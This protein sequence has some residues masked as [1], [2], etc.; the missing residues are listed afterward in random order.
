MN[1]RILLIDDDPELGV[2][3]YKWF[4]FGK[5]LMYTV[6]QLKGL[7]DL[8]RDGIL[9]LGPGDG[10]V[11][12]GPEA[13]EIISN[14]YHIGIRGEN[15]FDCS[16]LRR[17]GLDSGA[18]I[19]V[20][21]EKD[22]LSQNELAYFESDAFVLKREFKDY[23][24]E[25][26]KTPGSAIQRLGAMNQLR[27]DVKV[28]FD[29]ET[30][31]MPMEIDLMITGAALC[32]NRHSVFFSF[33]DIRENSTDKEFSE[34]IYAFGYVLR[35]YA[36]SIWVYNVQF[37]QQVTW[38]FFGIE[39]EFNDASVYNVMDGLH[40]KNYS[41]KWSTQRLIGGGDTVTPSLQNMPDNGGI[42]PWDTDFDRLE[43]LLDSMYY[44]VQQIP[45]T[46]GKKNT[47]RVLKVTPS[48]YQN[49]PE[50]K[51]I[52]MRYPKYI[53]EFER[54]INKYFGRPFL[55]IP[56]DILGYYC[57][58]DAFYTVEIP[59]EN[60]C[61]Y[62]GIC[63]EI[64]LNNQRLGALLHRGGMFKDENFRLAYNEECKHSEAYG[65]TYAA[66]C[67]CKWKMDKHSKKMADPKKYNPLWL[68]LMDRQEF[69]NGDPLEITKTLLSSNIND[70]YDT[71]FDEGKFMMTYGEDFTL[72]MKSTLET[73][74]KEIK[75]KGKIDESIIRKKKLLGLV[76]GDLK[77]YLKLPDSL[78]NKHI[79][80]EKYMWYER[81]YKS[82]LKI[83]K[84]GLT[85]DNVPDKIWFLGKVWDR[86]DYTEYVLENFFKCSSPID[87][88]EITGEL[89][90]LFPSQTTFL[91]TIYAGINKLPGGKNFYSNL[92]ITN[93]EDG[94]KHFMNEWQIWWNNTDGAGVTTYPV[95]FNPTYPNEVFIDAYRYWSSITNKK[96]AVEEDLTT[97]WDSFDGYLKQSTYF[98]FK[99]DYKLMEQPYS[100]NDWNLP[101][102]DFIR[103]LVINIM[104]YK[105][106]RKM[107]TAYTDETAMFKAT[108][109][110]VMVDPKTLMPIRDAAPNEPGSVIKMFPKYEVMKKETKRWSSGY[111]T[112]I[113]HSDVKDVISAPPGYLLTYFDISSAEVR[114]AAYRSGDPVMVHLFETKQDLY[115]HV[116]K[117]YFGDTR[118]NGM[119]KSEKKKW[120]KAFKTILLGVI[121]GMGTRTLAGRLG[122]DE[123]TAQSL[124]DT[125]MNEFKVLKK[126][127]EYNMAYPEKHDG[128]I[129]QIYGDTLR[130]RS[131][132]FIRKPDGS[133][134]K[135]ETMRVQRH[136]INWLIQS[137]SA[138]TLAAGFYNNIIEGHKMGLNL[139]PIIVVHD[140]NTNYVPI[141]SLF[142]LRG[143]YDKNFTGYCSER[144]KSPFLFDLFLGCAYQSAAE[145]KQIDKVTIE[146]TASAHIINGILNKIDTESHLIVET[147][148]PREQIIPMYVNDRM[149]RFI[150][151]GG[152]SLIKD[153]SEYTVQIRKIGMK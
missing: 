36:E 3:L 35:K 128:F 82:F 45:G 111:H 21:H 69:Y 144:V 105:K 84:N 104:Y 124:I 41:L 13:F 2:D 100:E 126:Y 148:I 83:W 9:K 47:E 16:Q 109:R 20:C 151:E 77:N 23:T 29:Y 53:G 133:Q 152:C 5:I 132:R 66:T 1:K 134:D 31:G 22:V 50:W 24:W 71:G 55:N 125:V 86:D 59:I 49:T 60:E 139:V 108:D 56:S 57:C 58:L 80:L 11:L 96:K 37:E 92:G 94:Y 28:G 90:D 32:A 93:V 39:C 25:I 114:T 137:G 91:T 135:F 72:F 95:G 88:A 89:I 131:W 64:F 33:L 74:M 26:V 107:R 67:R 136:G 123:V 79:E 7:S 146:M 118:W 138:L 75:F 115:I 117:L 98:S 19:K 46:K 130:S 121:Y 48:D 120:R 122:V 153:L 129:N 14:R 141:D 81:A 142:E 143:A 34:F 51:E 113:S 15:Y 61:R 147:S 127:V 85:I 12:V 73:R 110:L 18:F 62:P 106:Y 149:E 103:K 63:H 42:V 145:V 150:L 4:G 140:S 65:I 99:N 116:A 76:S 43:E 52:C 44:V 68:K 54:L 119:D 27:S 17:I 40:S 38:R 102:F 10:A 78:G 97:T 101:V 70:S 30:S 8:E 87:S 112:I 6:S